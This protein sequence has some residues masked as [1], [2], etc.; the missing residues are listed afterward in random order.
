MAGPFG[1]QASDQVPLKGISEQ[2]IVA[3]KYHR[4]NSFNM[5]TGF[6]AFRNQ[7]SVK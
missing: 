1:F 5:Q 3:G 7:K 6:H 4:L 2:K